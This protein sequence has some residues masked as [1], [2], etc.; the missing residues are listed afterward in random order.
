MGCTGAAPN[1]AGKRM[2]DTTMTD[3]GLFDS[4]PAR[5]ATCPRCQGH[6]NVSIGYALHPSSDPIVGA[7]KNA[8]HAF[9][10]GSFDVFYASKEAAALATSTRRSVAFQCIDYV[11]ILNP[12][13]DPDQVARAWW[14]QQYG[15]TPEATW[16]RR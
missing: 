2:N 15:E 12:G 7:P 14:L 8:I 11:V 3:E 6:G 16:A 5:T 10:A 4:R 13:D 1:K 9:V